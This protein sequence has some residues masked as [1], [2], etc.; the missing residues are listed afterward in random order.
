MRRSVWPLLLALVVIGVLFLLVFPARTYVAQ[1]RSLTAAEHRLHVLNVENAALDRRVAKLQ[2]DS[3]IERIA[4]E[5]YGLVRPGEE[6]YAI[7][8][9]PPPPEPETPPKPPAPHRNL[10]QRL[11]HAV[12]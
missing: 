2:D 7:L 8:P 4:R 5:Q 1:R 10:V 9:A 11:W 3:E 6:A 12:F